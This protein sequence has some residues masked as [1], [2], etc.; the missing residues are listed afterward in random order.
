[1]S[2]NGAEFCKANHMARKGNDWTISTLAW[3]LL[4]QYHNPGTKLPQPWIFRI[5]RSFVQGM[6]YIRRPTR[7]ELV[8][9]ALRV[10]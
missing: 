8:M 4:A 3:D 10:K 2:L 7:R 1:M 6:R 5:E 9:R